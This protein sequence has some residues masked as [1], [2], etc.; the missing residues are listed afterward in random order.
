MTAILGELAEVFA[1]YSE[2]RCIPQVEMDYDNGGVVLTVQFLPEAQDNK[3]DGLH[4]Y[5]LY[6]ELRYLAD[7]A[8]M[9]A[10]AAR[11]DISSEQLEALLPKKGTP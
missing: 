4:V 11:Y 6:G 3:S 9:R 10:I 2:L 5:E 1:P 7:L 8:Q